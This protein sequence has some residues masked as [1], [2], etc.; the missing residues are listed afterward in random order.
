KAE[1]APSPAER[2]A[3]GAETYHKETAEKPK[4]VAEKKSEPLSAEEELKRT[5]PSTSTSSSRTFVE[6]TPLPKSQAETRITESVPTPTARPSEPER[7]L[8]ESSPPAIEETPPVLH[9]PVTEEKPPI[10]NQPSEA[11]RESAAAPVKKE[12]P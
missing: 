7:E 9:G 10:A 3:R 12:T 6:P 1:A 11:S 5:E 8:K 2:A 4:P